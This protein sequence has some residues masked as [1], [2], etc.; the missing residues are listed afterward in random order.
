M[1][2]AVP[3]EMLR[4]WIES[5]RADGSWADI[6]YTDR[7]AADWIPV[8]HLKRIRSLLLMARDSKEEIQRQEECLAAVHRGLDFWFQH[9]PC[10]CNWWH[11]QIGVPALVGTILLV[12][13]SA[14]TARETA[15]AVAILRRSGWFV[16]REGDVYEPMVWTGANLLWIAVNMLMRA[17]LEKEPGILPDMFARVANEIRVVEKGEEGIQADFSFHQHGPLLYNGG[18]GFSF[19]LECLQFTAL[20]H[21]TCWQFSPLLYERLACFLLDGQQWMIHGLLR[22]YS[23]CDRN[24]A[25]P[26]CGLISPSSAEQDLS[27]LGGA[28]VKELENFSARLRGEIATACTGNR[29]FWRSDFM[30]HRRAGFSTSVRLSSTRTRTS[31]CCN[32]EGKLSHHVADGLTYLY[33]TGLEYVDIFPV[34]DW[35]K[36]PGITCALRPELPRKE[37]DW[38]TGGSHRSGGVSDGTCGMAVHDLVREEVRARKAWF[39]FDDFWVCLGAGIRSEQDEEVITAVEQCWLRGPVWMEGKNEPVEEGIHTTEKARW[40]WHQGTGYLFS[41]PTALAVRNDLQRGSWRLIGPGSDAPLEGKVFSLWLSHG[42]KPSSQTYAYTVFAQIDRN[43]LQQESA[44]PSFRILANTENIQAVMLSSGQMV[45]AAF[46][47]EGE[48]ELPDLGVLVVQQPCLVLLRRDPE[49]GRFTVSV[50][51]PGGEIAKASVG[52]RSV[53]GGIGFEEVF[54]LPSGIEAGKSVSKV[55]RDR[56]A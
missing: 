39:Y 18:Y 54:E 3:V 25:R 38:Q 4:G 43:R 48:L 35:Q 2:L 11:N 45:E 14:A 37:L 20:T 19:G 53:M 24:I 50:S 32:D 40:V 13:E 30:V 55:V 27:I 16:W 6:D 12:M 15:G 51:D 29:H 22:D 26:G 44:A 17:I 1:D 34:W 28:R 5:Q 33:K 46:W 49:K 52:L 7:Q 47:Q 21:G 41:D 36:L 56:K 42:V 9:D 31:E 23:C 8:I 10:S